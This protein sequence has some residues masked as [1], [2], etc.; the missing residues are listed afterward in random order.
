MTKALAGLL[1]EN[2]D[3]IYAHLS[4]GSV[5]WEHLVDRMRGSSVARDE[6]LWTFL[7]A[8]GYA[9]A[10]SDGVRQLTETLAG[11]DLHH[12]NP[13]IWLEAMPMSPRKKEGNT[14]LDL[15]L[16]TIRCREGTDGGIEL[17]DVSEP[18]IC[19]GE[20]KLF[21]DLSHGVTH[22]PHRNQLA[23]VVGECLLF[24]AAGGQVCK[25]HIRRPGNPESLPVYTRAVPP[26]PVQIQGIR[27]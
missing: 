23:R 20:A 26:L 18:W 10:G 22:D 17:D 13:R 1:S 9:I 25:S 19:F 5:G 16:G 27:D 7:A 24:P 2:K 21:S 6:Q 8:C 12:P 3:A 15:A 4:L 11:T 14:H